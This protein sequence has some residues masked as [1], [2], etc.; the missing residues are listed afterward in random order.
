MRTSRPDPAI[1][2]NE[3]DE[4]APSSL[5]VDATGTDGFEDVTGY[6]D[7]MKEKREK[8]ERK[9]KADR[10]DRAAN[11]AKR[12]KHPIV[13]GIAGFFF[14]LFLTVELLVFGVLGSDSIFMLVLP[15]LGIFVGVALALWGPLGQRQGRA[16]SNNS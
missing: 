5:L 4:P 6:G 8:Q 9:A 13:G 12:R 14:F 7:K 3:R 15:I 11:P 10:A 2:P 1:R 16:E